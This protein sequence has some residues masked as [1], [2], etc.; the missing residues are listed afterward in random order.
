MSEPSSA[1]TRLGHVCGIMYPRKISLDILSLRKFASKDVNFEC[2]SEWSKEREQAFDD[3]F[4]TM[5]SILLPRIDRFVTQGIMNVATPA[6]LDA[7]RAVVTHKCEAYLASFPGKDTLRSNW[8]LHMDID[9]LKD[10]TESFDLE[11]LASLDT[12]LEYRL[13]FMQAADIYVSALGLNAPYGVTCA[14][15]DGTAPHAARQRSGQRDHKRIRNALRQSMLFSTPA[16]QQGTAFKKPLAYMA[17]AI[18]ISDVDEDAL[19]SL[20]QDLV[21]LR[22]KVI[23]AK[24]EA[25]SH[26]ETV[27][28]TAR[29]YKSASCKPRAVV[30][31]SPRIPPQI[32]PHSRESKAEMVSYVLKGLA[33]RRSDVGRLYSQEERAFGEAGG[34]L[35]FAATAR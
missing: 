21:A 19:P 28:E 3:F 16:A 18:Q 26:L 34:G 10:P 35:Y 29:L 14:R 9:C 8:C 15:W 1:I 5:D 13:Q 17:T 12:K 20:L 4:D 30:R 32:Q 31:P 22:E 25:L 6:T 33:K 11:R 24:V 2:T 23:A 7:L 27:K